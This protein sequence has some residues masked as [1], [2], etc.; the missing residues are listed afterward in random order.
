MKKIILPILI[1]LLTSG[2]IF[3]KTNHDVARKTPKLK[4]EIP[5]GGVW[6]HDNLFIDETEIR[7]LDYLEFLYW[8]NRHEPQKMKALLP[9]T[10]V[11]RDKSVYNEPYVDYYLRHP[12]Y[13]EY[14]VVGISY[15][16]AVEFCQWRSDRV[17]EF[18]YIRD[19]KIK[20]KDYRGD[21]IYPHPEVMHFRLPTKEE[22]EYAAA[23]GL[24]QDEFPY[25]YRSLVGKNGL[26][27]SN[28][29]EYR[30]LYSRT[31]RLSIPHLGGYYENYT[32]MTSPVASFFPNDY[33]ILNMTGNVSEIIADSLFKG[34]NY[35]TSLDGST[36]KTN[37]EEYTRTDSLGFSY[38]NRFTFRYKG[39][40][41]WLG[42]RCVCEV[43]KEKGSGY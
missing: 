21:S 13:W 42:F 29:S 34:L 24:D 14:P 26:P 20:S 4:Y 15:E 16:Q 41:A 31:R 37:P 30:N 40:R 25:G 18:I 28:T 19:H 32:D 39:P 3:H 10:L 5:P 22:W 11:W 27:V 1:V 33:G 8:I 17:N 9:D 35:T 23:A 2:F 6:L 38:D 36:F 7:N 12:A 43:K